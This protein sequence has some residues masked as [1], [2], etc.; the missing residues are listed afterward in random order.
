MVA[1]VLREHT[2]AIL[3][4]CAMCAI[5]LACVL[6]GIFLD[7]VSVEIPGIALGVV[8][9]G[10]ATRLGDRAGQILGVDS[11]VLC[12]LSMVNPRSTC[13]GCSYSNDHNY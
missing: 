3:V 11:V 13:R 5:G 10:F 2:G 12:I 8:G 4:G 6:V 9:S 7:G 1:D